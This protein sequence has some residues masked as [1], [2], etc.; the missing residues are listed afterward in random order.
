M[1]KQCQDF[2][3][4]NDDDDDDD[5]DEEEDVG[6]SG[7]FEFFMGLFEKDGELRGFY[8]KN[9]EKGDFCCLVCGAIGE[10]IGKRYGNCV[11]LVQ[12]ANTVSKTRRR[13]AHRNF[14]RAVCRVLGWEIDKLP[15]VFD[16]LSVVRDVQAQV[17]NS[18]WLF[19]S[20]HFACRLK[21]FHMLWNLYFLKIR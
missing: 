19:F 17:K 12:H 13:V 18:S 16:G 3:A 7:N 20:V 8:E 11:G 1:L 15:G 4:A 5:E 6:E 14:G 10:K 9:W 2:L 21:I